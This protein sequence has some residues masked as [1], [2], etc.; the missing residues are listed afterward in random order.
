[1]QRD[2]RMGWHWRNWARPAREWWP[3]METRRTPLSQRPSRKPSLTVTSS[4]LLLSRTW[5]ELPSA[6]PPVT[7]LLLL[8]AHSLLSCPEPMTRSVWEPSPSPMSTWWA[9]TVGSLLGKM[10]PLRWPWRTW[11]C[12]VPSQRALCFTPVM[13]C[14]R[15]GLLSCPLTQKLVLQ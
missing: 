5:W 13:R 15:K 14:P 9:P 2:G 4:A 6:A 8:P 12:S 1:C 7:E 10:V 3:W 11:P